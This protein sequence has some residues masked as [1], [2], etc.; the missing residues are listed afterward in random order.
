M[1]YMFRG[2]DSNRR[3]NTCRNGVEWSLKNSSV[4]LKVSNDKFKCP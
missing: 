3:N 4:G 1:S 2:F